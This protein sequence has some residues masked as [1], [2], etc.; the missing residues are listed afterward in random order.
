MCQVPRQTSK[1]QSLWSY[2][3]F[4]GKSDDTKLEG[5]EKTLAFSNH[6]GSNVLKA[7]LKKLESMK[8]LWPRTARFPEFNE[9]RKER[10]LKIY[11]HVSF[12]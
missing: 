8:G 1:Y 3:E 5:C 10:Q 7:C 4:S 2:K 9:W 11:N 12:Y 6:K